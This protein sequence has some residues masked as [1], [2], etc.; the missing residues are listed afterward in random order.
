MNLLNEHTFLIISFA[1][2][3]LGVY[4][5]AL[6]RIDT[7]LSEA[8]KNIK[9]TISDAQKSKILHETR[10]NELQSMMNEINAAQTHAETSAREAA[11]RQVIKDNEKIEEIICKE[12]AQYDRETRKIELTLISVRQEKYIDAVIN[13]AEQELSDLQT[14]KS[15]QETAVMTSLEMLANISEK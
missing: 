8:I 4:K 7:Q 5:F 14:D 11:K 3:I 2:A 9:G 6:K 10:I 13:E 12:R 15:F 1:I